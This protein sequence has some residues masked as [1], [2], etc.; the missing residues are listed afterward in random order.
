MNFGFSYEEFRKIESNLSDVEEKIIKDQ[1]K[2]VTEGNSCFENCSSVEMEH[3]FW[4]FR[5]GWICR[6]MILTD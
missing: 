4:L 1:F 5:H 2:T 6:K 3:Y